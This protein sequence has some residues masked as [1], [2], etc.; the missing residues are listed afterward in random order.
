MQLIKVFSVIYLTAVCA[1]Q[2]A[3][4]EDV[5]STYREVAPTT[6]AVTIVP[7]IPFLQQQS[8]WSDVFPSEKVVLNC[9]VAGSS[10]WTFTWYRGG[11]ALQD[12]DPSVSLSAGGSVLTVTAE[13]QT[14]S[15]IY[16]CKGHHK[17]KGIT[18]AES[19]KLELSVYPNVPKPTLRRSSDYPE[20]FPKESVTFTC[21]VDVSSGWEYLWYL[22]GAE[23]QA[24]SN[25]GFTIA[26]INHPDSG[27]YHCKAK[28]G[29]F[30]TDDSEKTTLK[31]SD[32]RNPSLSLLT[33]WKD[34]F[35]KETV[36]FE[37][38]VDSPGWTFTWY[39]NQVHIQDN[40]FLPLDKMKPYFNIT[41]I[42][43][44]YKGGY[45]CK[46]HLE[47]RGVSS[48][49]SN[50]VDVEVY[51]NTP[52]P[53]LSKN[54]AFN[55]M[56]VGEAVNFTCNVDVASGWEYL[57]YKDGEKLP[58]TSRTIGF[59]LSLSNG[60]KYSCKANRGDATR[61]D[62]SKEKQQDVL[63]IPAP[64]VKKSTPWSDVFPRESVKL[65][66]E[67]KD[68]SDWIY[69]WFRDGQEVQADG[70]LSINSASPV[71]AGQY[72][73]MGSLKGRSV[74]SS[75]SSGFNLTVHDKPP[76]V[77]LT[78]DPDYKVMFPEE[79]VSFIC[80]IKVSSGWQYQW[81]KDDKPLDHSEKTYPIQLNGTS[82]GLYECKVHRRTGAIY[83][84]QSLPLK[85]EGN[86]PKPSMTQN[87][88]IDKLYAGESVSFEC[89]IEHSSGW[90][91]YWY[92]DG[93]ELPGPN[94]MYSIDDAKLSSNG[95]YKCRA[96][97]NNYYTE[98]SDGRLLT[99]SEIPVPSLKKVTEWLDVFPTESVTLSCV[100]N[101]SSDWKYTWYKDGQEVQKTP[102]NV[103]SFDGDASRLNITSASPLN[104]GQY[105]CSARL[106]SRSVNSS[107]SSGL[108]LSVYDKTPRVTLT[109]NP[110]H[111]VMHTGDPVTFSC[112]INVSTGWKYLWFK[113]DIPLAESG[114]NHNIT[115]VLTK[116]T[117]S[118]KCQ[119]KRGNTAVF[120][121]SQTQAVKLNVEERPKAEI[122]LLTGWSEVFSTDTLL[123]KCG[124]QNSQDLW[125]YTW[126]K[127]DV[128]LPSDLSQT[129]K[130]TPQND[131]VQSDYT[132]QGIRT[133]R[134]SYSKTSD[135][136]KTKNLLLKRRILLSIS[137]CIFF[138]II[139]V[140][141]GCIILRFTRK[142]AADEY[143]PEEAEL[144]ARMDKKK[145]SD[146]APC[147]LVQYITDA[148]L[149]APPKEGDENGMICSE[150][151]PLP[152][153]PQEDQA[154][155]TE[156]HDEADNGGM[157]S[158]KQ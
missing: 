50:T 115:S 6:Q 108:T 38:K 86:K 133:G 128:E 117:G 144:F 125:N 57:W 149:N 96:R 77:T 35:E 21:T 60:G 28:R 147:P 33:P 104:R 120:H 93:K 130:V 141:L 107:L 24:A 123:L 116:N 155:T 64:S 72:T 13:A 85:I 74:S 18:T 95:T 109:Q 20:M 36:N 11:Q 10:D 81:Y 103:L 88:N 69:T 71:H 142:P 66:C 126:F 75:K 84:S 37:C 19:N 65:S 7:P 42:T 55:P 158:F 106:K 12:S 129:H 14:S 132:C 100:M 92:K 22:N 91:Y 153:T 17:T 82:G 145:D 89:K 23:I 122:I 127:A 119:T 90:E 113:D 15:G 135:H 3:D 131:P 2:D 54:P 118:Y 62:F 31:V 46:A 41:S 101:G 40:P 16:S 61:T 80:N 79:S 143:K 49:F 154:V 52:K 114:A 111:D 39:K 97:R 56:Y 1:A 53:T 157:V 44:A 87:P 151:T 148:A 137:G 76:S 136:Y 51:D 34:V 48:G 98:C 58:G 9:S 29:S 59:P 105:K 112:H 156:S 110:S 73:C 70:T 47:H 67:M 27:E 152:I 68:S 138:G 43:Q 94:S 26:S 25:D 146:D 139:F 5:T 83:P 121:S 63:E 150:T 78:Q 102:N 4:D 8:A 140:F 124:V 134:P 30:S 45:S 99:I 32:P